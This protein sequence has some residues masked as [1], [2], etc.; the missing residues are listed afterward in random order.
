MDESHPHT[1]ESLPLHIVLLNNA[2]YAIFFSLFLLYSTTILPLTLRSWR[3]LPSDCPPLKA[4]AQ[5]KAASRSKDDSDWWFFPSFETGLWLVTTIQRDVLGFPITGDP[6]YDAG[7][8]VPLGHAFLSLCDILFRHELWTTERFRLFHHYITILG[9]VKMVQ[10]RDILTSF[11]WELPGFLHVLGN[12]I[13][14]LLGDGP[15]DRPAL[16]VH[17]LYV[18]FAVVA[19]IRTLIND[20]HNASTSPRAHTY[21]SLSTA[22]FTIPFMGII[23]SINNWGMDCG[24][25]TPDGAHCPPLFAPELGLEVNLWCYVLAVTVGVCWVVQRVMSRA[26]TTSLK[27][28]KAH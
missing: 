4:V 17:T 18:L 21:L 9:S 16:L 27:R 25:Y 2:A 7:I 23:V 3:I 14:Y 5:E 11:V 8:L 1:E 26:V 22:I 19:C 10:E 6:L 13:W 24:Q 15:G 12:T 20:A 28:S